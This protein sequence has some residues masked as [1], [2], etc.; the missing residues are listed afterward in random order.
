MQLL[1]LQLVGRD[2]AASPPGSKY[3]TTVLVISE[4]PLYLE[5]SVAWTG[6]TQFLH[7]Q[8]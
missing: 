2:V 4:N 3:F 7:S 6:L 8:L 1:P 5:T